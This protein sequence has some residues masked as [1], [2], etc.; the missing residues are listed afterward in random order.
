MLYKEYLLLG[1]LCTA[2]VKNGMSQGEN[3]THH[4]LFHSINNIGLLKG[5]FGNSFQLET[6][7]GI[8]Y[9]KWFGGLGIGIDEYRLRTIPLFIDLRKEIGKSVNKWFVFADAG[10]SV[11]WQRDSD[12]KTFLGD[13]HV[14]NGFC[15]AA[16]TGYSIKLN[17]QLHLLLS[18]GYSYKAMKEEGRNLDPRMFIPLPGGIWVDTVPLYGPLTSTQHTFHRWILKVG[19]SF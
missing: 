3:M 11:Y 8:Q 12:V 15:A 16:G 6:I 7:N 9:G 18:G 13:S 10:C 4:P 1:L 19:I 2:M 14:K 17:R 5:A